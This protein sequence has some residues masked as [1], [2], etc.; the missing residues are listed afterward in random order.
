MGPLAAVGLGVALTPLRGVTVPSNFTFAFLALTIAVAEFGGRW[1]A[2]TT[3]LA[4]ALSLDFFLTEPYLQLAIAE[5]HDVIAFVGLAGC[6]LLAAALG[7]R[8]RERVTDLRAARAHADVVRSAVGELGRSAALGARLAM[9]VDAARAT[10]PLAALA[11][12]DVAGERLIASPRE[13]ARAPAPDAVLASDTLL[14]REQHARRGRDS[15]FPVPAEGASL[16][17][18]F[19][20]RPVGWLDL[21][22]NGSAVATGARREL[23]SL[24]GIVAALIARAQRDE[25]GLPPGESQE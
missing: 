11:V 12:R 22:G 23:L 1:A 13:H 8:R 10:F 2:V 17:L 21:W 4:S 15:E 19:E 20:S 9:I 18:Q 5:K 14:T 6:S 7:A 25:G 24:A 16:A 3:A